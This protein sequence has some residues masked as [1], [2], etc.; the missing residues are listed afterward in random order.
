M[1]RMHSIRQR[2]L[3]GIH[4]YEFRAESKWQASL[5]EDF[6]KTF[7]LARHEKLFGGEPSVLRFLCKVR[8]AVCAENFYEGEAEPGCC[9]EGRA[10]GLR[11]ARQALD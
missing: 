9:V 1:Q 5:I 6:I 11:G 8:D 4:S 2:Y 10:S 3:Y 7:F